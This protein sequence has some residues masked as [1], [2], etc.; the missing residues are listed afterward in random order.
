MDING[1]FKL[2]KD[3][4]IDEFGVELTRQIDTLHNQFRSN[5]LAMKSLYDRL[6][7]EIKR[8]SEE[9][10]CSKDEMSQ[11]IKSSKDEMSK[12]IKSSKVEIIK[13]VQNLQVKVP[14][15]PGPNM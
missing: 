15:N 6:S 2:M 1:S 4:I 7:E 9:I 12:E 5:T 11:E 3:E 13:E 10:K 8:L 14:N